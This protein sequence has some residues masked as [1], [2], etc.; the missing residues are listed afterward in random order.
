MYNNSF[1]VRYKYAPV[2]VS[3]SNNDT[4]AAAHVHNEIE[5]LYIIS[6][7]AENK[8]GKKNYHA[9]AGE[10]YYINPYEVHSVTNIRE[11]YY[12][13]CICFDCSLIV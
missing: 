6:G 11:P 2:A 5:M 10:L 4:P 1:N 9:V 12:H 8:I 7:S 13:R 3:I